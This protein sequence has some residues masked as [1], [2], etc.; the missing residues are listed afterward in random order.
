ML[1]KKIS[2]GSLL[3]VV[4]VT[5]ADFAQLSKKKTNPL[6]HIEKGY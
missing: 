4:S 2:S 1:K 3:Q 5:T 6:E